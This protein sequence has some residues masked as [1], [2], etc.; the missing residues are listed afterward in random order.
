MVD[1]IEDMVISFKNFGQI[2]S[3]RMNFNNQLHFMEHLF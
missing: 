2:Y 3:F 1:H